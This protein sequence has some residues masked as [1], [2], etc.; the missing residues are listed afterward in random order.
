MH[1]QLQ[2][3]SAAP[4][5]SMPP[6]PSSTDKGT[7]PTPVRLLHRVRLFQ[8]LGVEG[9]A[10]V[11]RGAEHL[12]IPAGTY[13]FRND[14]C[15]TVYLLEAGRVAITQTAAR[16]AERLVRWVGP[17]ELFGAMG[18]LRDQLRPASAHTLC[19][20]RALSWKRESIG[21]LMRTYP[22]LALN[23]LG[24]LEDQLWEFQRHYEEH[25]EQLTDRRSVART[26][27]R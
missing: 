7:D 19:R 2:Q 27:R 15:E 17:T 4:D 3:H 24:D 8:G 5:I 23:A 10:A 20:C 12:D 9:L 21:R 14:K 26:A 1:I 25:A 13:I 18:Q 16:G 22:L 11:V 6:P